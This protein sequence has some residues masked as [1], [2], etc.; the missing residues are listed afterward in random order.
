MLSACLLLILGFMIAGNTMFTHTA[1]AAT[2]VPGTTAITTYHTNN[3]RTGNNTT[4]TTLTLSNV[5]SNQFGKRVT[6]PVDGQIYA[7][8][9]VLPNLTINGTAHNV[10]FVATEHDSVYAFDTDQTSAVAPLWKTSFLTSSNVTTVPAD[11]L[12][13]R[14]SSS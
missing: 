7:Q 4:E 3:Q 13:T 14:Y 8:P 1:H 12:Y 11:D 5:N 6:Y 9:L 2:F 10:V